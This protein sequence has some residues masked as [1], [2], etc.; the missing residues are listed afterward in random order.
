[1]LFLN[2]GQAWQLMPWKA[3]G[4]E[5]Q[6][7]VTQGLGQ[8][9]RECLLNL[10]V[11]NGCQKKDKWGE[12][13]LIYFPRKASLRYIILSFLLL[14]WETP[15]RKWQMVANNK[16]KEMSSFKKEILCFLSL[17]VRA[18]GNVTELCNSLVSFWV[19]NVKREII[20][21]V[22]EF[23]MSLVFKKRGK[24]NCIYQKCIPEIRL[25]HKTFGGHQHWG[26]M[27][28]ILIK[29][30]VVPMGQVLKPHSLTEKWVK[31]APQCSTSVREGLRMG[32]GEC[33]N[34][35]STKAASLRLSGCGRNNRS[36]RW[37]LVKWSWSCLLPLCMRVPVQCKQGAAGKIMFSLFCR[38][39]FANCHYLDSHYPLCLLAGGFVQNVPEENPRYLVCFLWGG[40]KINVLFII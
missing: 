10:N 32:K 36:S 31:P 19:Y 37:C 24:N 20:A 27:M 14:G 34:L 25:S 33:L 38:R 21:S 4:M 1:M 28:N 22:A 35:P 29:I 39:Y 11:A 15:V 23:Q 40:G 13:G 3:V 6:P 9:A 8:Q 17:V 5:L 30:M 18:V 7:S 16:R 26:W 12:A 2:I